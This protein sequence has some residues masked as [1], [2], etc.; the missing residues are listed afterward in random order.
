VSRLLRA[1]LPRT[2]TR[3]REIEQNDR[4]E[5]V[6]GS[7]VPYENPYAPSLWPRGVTR[8]GALAGLGVATEILGALRLMGTR[9]A[10]DDFDTTPDTTHS[11]T[12]RNGG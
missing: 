4:A 8:I 11:A 5:K 3:V 12:P 9:G 10:G 2:S 7:P 1:I 6:E